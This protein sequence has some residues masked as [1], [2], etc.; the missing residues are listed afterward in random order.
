MTDQANTA[1]ALQQAGDD[2]VGTEMRLE[3]VQWIDHANCTDWYPQSQII[4]EF[5]P[6]EVETVGWTIKETADYIVLVSSR[7]AQTE[8]AARSVLIMKA[9][10]DKRL[11]LNLER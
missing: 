2:P 10:I 5:V 7:C 6:C 9:M 3:F 1:T 8:K 11:P 4:E